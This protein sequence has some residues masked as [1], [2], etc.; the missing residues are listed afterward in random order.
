MKYGIKTKTPSGTH[1]LHFFNEIKGYPSG[2]VSFNTFDEATDY[3]QN[4]EI[5]N[6][7]VEVINDNRS[8]TEGPRLI[9]D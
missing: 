9:T 8:D 7:T 3:A 2:I 6:Y 1:W 5:P 4:H